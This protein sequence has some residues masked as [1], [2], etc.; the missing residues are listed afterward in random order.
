MSTTINN[1]GNSFIDLYEKTE[2]S[3]SSKLQGDLNKDYSKSTDEELMDVCNQFESYFMEQ[4]FKSLEKMV[5][6]SDDEDTS[7]SKTVDYF[8]DDMIQKIANDSTKNQGLGLAK[9]LYESMKRQYH[10]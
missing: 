10:V 2:N 9:T 3:T 6:D 7:V 4:V 1:Y 8:K 5:P